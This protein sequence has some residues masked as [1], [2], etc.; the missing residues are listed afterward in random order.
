MKRSLGN[1]FLIFMLV[2]GL[3]F[4]VVCSQV[5]AAPKYT[6]TDLNTLTGINRVED[7]NSQGM[8]VGSLY[9]AAGPRACVWQAETGLID[10][11]PGKAVAISDSGYVVG[12]INSQ[13]SF[14]WK[15]DKGMTVLAINS[16]Y[17][18]VDAS[19][20]NDSGQVVGGSYIHMQNF[21]AFLWEADTGM[22]D[23]GT[24]G[25]LSSGAEA[26]NNS[27][28]VVG[29]ASNHAFL[30]QKETGM[31]NLG[32]LGGSACS[33][34]G[35]NDAGQVVGYSR[36]ASGSSHAFIWDKNAV[37]RMLDIGTLGGSYSGAEGID[38][39]GQVI[40]SSDTAD[41]KRHAFIWKADTGMIDLNS[42]ID[43]ALGL[44]LGEARKILD[45][46]SILAR[47]SWCLGKYV[48]L[49]DVLLTPLV[50]QVQIDIKPGDSLNIINMKSKGTTPVAILASADFDPSTV[51]PATV[52]LAG[53]PV[54]LKSKGRYMASL[55]DMNG[56]GLKDLVLHVVT[57][58]LNLTVED[59]KAV[60][61]GE[62]FD[63]TPIVGEDSVKVIAKK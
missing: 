49:H 33:A 54:A 35:I 27:G 52:T 26:I 29:Y 50:I 58:Q 14:V 13:Q 18:I 55:K 17:S 57:Q 8:F 3:L 43:P 19:D 11:G 34:Y 4:V 30:W 63:G 20:V 47:Y 32:S 38:N 60:L 39:H 61:E 37:L 31:V 10:L 9:Y 2:L 46:G 28:Q 15:A 41:G 12:R 42:L 22:T 45:D 40:G 24:L 36:T 21:R 48:G 1:L 56:D 25:G 7:V 23:L 44:E 16:P 6:V 59:T 62:T 53:A 5:A 51:D